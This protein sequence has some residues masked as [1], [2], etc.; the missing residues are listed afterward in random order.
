MPS[1]I[2]A[3]SW[4]KNEYFRGNEKGAF[5]IQSREKFVAKLSGEVGKYSRITNDNISSL[6]KDSK[7]EQIKNIKTTYIDIISI[8]VVTVL[9]IFP[10]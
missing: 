5:L 10:R 2:K 3:V 6:W 8:N 4:Q 7:V 9:R 1:E